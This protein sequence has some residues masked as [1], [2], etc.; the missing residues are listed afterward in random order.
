MAAADPL[1]GVKADADYVASILSGIKGPIVLER[2]IT[3][4]P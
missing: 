2:T 3:A 4:V 1:R